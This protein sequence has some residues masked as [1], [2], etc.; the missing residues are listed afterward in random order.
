MAD[1]ICNFSY[2]DLPDAVETAKV[3]NLALLEKKSTIPPAVMRPV[4]MAH[5]KLD[6]FSEIVRPATDEDRASK[7]YKR[8]LEAH[9]AEVPA[10][11]LPGGLISAV[12]EP[13]KEPSAD[14]ASELATGPLPAVIEAILPTVGD[15]TGADEHDDT[16]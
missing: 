5:I 8:W 16:P 11:I 15:E 1:T 7:D 13:P 9:P 6:G 2:L 10:A 3:R 4:L 14:L 12:Q